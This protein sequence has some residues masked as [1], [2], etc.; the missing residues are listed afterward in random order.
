M[1]GNGRLR[2]KKLQRGSYY[3]K[4]LKIMV[5]LSFCSIFL[6]GMVTYIGGTRLIK[7]EVSRT[8]VNQLKQVYND[9]DRQLV[10]LEKFLGEWV[11]NPV[12]SNRLTEVDFSTQFDV[13]REVIGALTTLEGSSPLIYDAQLYIQNVNGNLLISNSGGRA[14]VQDEARIRQYGDWSGHLWSRFWVD[15]QELGSREGVLSQTL[16]YKLQANVD[17][18]YGLLFVFLDEQ[19][20]NDT[21]GPVRADNAGA[22]FIVDETGNWITAGRGRG[23]EATALD[24]AIHARI[25]QE[26]GERGS[27]TY[28]WSKEDYRVTYET[29][30]RTGWRFVAATPLSGLMK[31]VLFLT[32]LI[33]AACL[34][35]LLLAGLASFLA[36]GRIYSPILRMLRAVAGGAPGQE[37]GQEPRD[38]LRYI[39]ERWN[40]AALESSKL[41]ARLEQHKDSLKT[42]FLLQLAQGH[43]YFVLEEELKQ[44]FR[45]YWWEPEGRIFTT[46]AVRIT[47]NQEGRSPFRKGDE[48]LLSFAA[49]NI[50]E[51]LLQK[52]IPETAVINFHDSTLSVIAAYPEGKNR[53]EL[54]KELWLAAEQVME[55]LT[56]Y[57]RVYATL[58]IGMPVKELSGIAK[59]MEETRQ[60]LGYRDMNRSG[61]IMDMEELMLSKQAATSYPSVLEKNI[62]ET[63][64]RGMAEETAAEMEAFIKKVQAAAG[65]EMLF[66]QQLSQLLGSILSQFYR[67]GLKP[68][69]I[70]PGVNYYEELLRLHDRE[71]LL[72]WFRR[73][74][75][76]PYIRETSKEA[77]EEERLISRVI[78]MLKE[79]YRSPISLELCA[80]R[81]GM[82]SNTLSIK[83]K[84][85]TGV[86]FIDYLTDIRLNKAKELLLHSTLRVNEIAEEVG[87][88]PTYFIR[89]FKKQEGMTPGQYRKRSADRSRRRLMHIFDRPAAAEKVHFCG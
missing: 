79:E 75:I 84:M 76:E 22:S 78:G 83:F 43:L 59:G 77:D 5:A 34:L 8:H 73:R 54:R 7:A 35:V 72:E 88:Q 11:Y 31:P 36:T 15:A 26:D 86:N 20:L 39:E 28:N 70:G 63:L 30:S 23:G 81:I 67:A 64:R 40:D 60:A 52:H 57:L 65:R 42:S 74:L 14:D 89:I 13:Y 58:V 46:L 48:R 6:V 66:K 55:A 47:G 37:Q 62:L 50:T 56:R 68:E 85:H 27:F 69:L 1:A 17:K 2:I 82:G 32:N 53:D 9:I 10:H 16:V 33:L 44:Q 12:L 38:E 24:G 49:T 19:A 45:E 29:L 18:P 3:K 41:R 61:Q 21:I 87:Y 25:M 80:E 4:T 71:E 51:E